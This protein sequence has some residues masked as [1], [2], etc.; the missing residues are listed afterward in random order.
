VLIAF[1]SG[2]TGHPKGTLDILAM[3]DTFA[4]HVAKIEPNDIFTGSPPV[5]FTFGLGALVAFPMRFGAS[6]VLVEQ[7]GPTTLLETIDR[8]QVTGIYT[9]PTAYRAMLGSVSDFSLKSLKHCFSAGEHLPKPTWEAWHEATGIKIIDGIGSTEMLHIF[10]SAA[11]DDI[12]PGST[13]KAVP[14]YRARI[15]DEQGD[16]VAVGEEGWLAVQGPTGCRY[17]DNADK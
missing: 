3:C 1:T 15:V 8:Y 11:G 4:R 2:T 14:G 5:A 9:A 16:P 17:L 6:T 12:R 10:I 13:G 7:F